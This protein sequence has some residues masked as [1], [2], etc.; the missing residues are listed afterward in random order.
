M[1]CH[2]RINGS[3]W[4]A[5]KLLENLLTEDGEYGTGLR[6]LSLEEHRERTLRK[7]ISLRTVDLPDSYSWYPGTV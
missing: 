2:R 1:A 7:D 5:P 4:C 3:I 6:F